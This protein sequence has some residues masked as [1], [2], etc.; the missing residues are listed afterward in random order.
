[1][2]SI[3]DPVEQKS[4]DACQRLMQAKW[5]VTDN[6][7]EVKNDIGGVLGYTVSLD[8]EQTRKLMNILDWK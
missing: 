8:I 1:M 2:T 6:L 7:E 5:L 3:I 4:V